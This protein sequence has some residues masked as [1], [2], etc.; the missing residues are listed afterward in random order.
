[1]NR[2]LAEILIS[3]RSVERDEAADRLPYD[4]MRVFDMSRPIAYVKYQFV[5]K[6]LS[7]SR[8][9]EYLDY[10]SL[11]DHPLLS[12]RSET[13]DRHSFIPVKKRKVG[14]V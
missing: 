6:Y 1:M 8:R 14:A 12:E 5:E 3:Q 7:R 4:G 13:P 2:P 10:D 9:I 11:W